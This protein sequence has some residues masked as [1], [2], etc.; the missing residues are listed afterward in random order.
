MYYSPDSSG[1]IV[2]PTDAVLKNQQYSSWTH[3]SDVRK[4][5]DYIKFSSPSG[6]INDIVPLE[7]LNN[8]WYISY[9]LPKHQPDSTPIICSMQRDLEFKLWH[10]RLVHP[11]NNTI[12][13]APKTCDGL[14][15]SLKAPDFHK[16]EACI[17]GK[18]HSHKKG[19][20]P[21]MSSDIRPGTFFEMDFGFIRGPSSDGK[22]GHLRSCRNGYN[23]Y[24]LI[25]DVATRYMWSFP[26]SSKDV[27]C[28]LIEKFLD[29]YGN[30]DPTADRIVRTDLGGELAKSLSFK[31]AISSKNFR[32]QTTA[33]ESSFQN[34]IVEQAHRT[35]ADMMRTMLVSAGLDANFWSDALLHAT[36][37]KNRL[38][39]ATLGI[40][41]F[42]AW[43]SSRP[44]LA[45]LRVFGSSIYVRTP[46]VDDGKLDTSRMH[47]G[48][49][50][51]FTPSKRN[52]KYFDL[53]T[54]QSKTSR[55]FVIDEA[56]F[57]TT[58]TIPPYAKDLLEYRKNER[59]KH[60][61]TGP[62]KELS[63]TPSNPSKN[64]TTPRAATLCKDLEII[65]SEL[66]LSSSPIGQ[67]A[68]YDVSTK[69]TDEYL[70]F[71]FKYD[72]KSNII[73]DTIEQRTPAN[74]IPRWRSDLRGATLLSISGELVTSIASAS[75]II[76]QQRILQNKKISFVFAP[77]EKEKSATEFQSTQLEF[78]QLSTIA[79]QH[80]AS[81]KDTKP[82]TDG[83]NPPIIDN[84]SLFAFVSQ[85]KGNNKAFKRSFLQ[86]QPDWPNWQQSEYK[87]LQAYEDQ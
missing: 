49:F 55:H 35:L 51:G 67:T 19:Y 84:D 32:L 70:G 34:G 66:V 78:D 25:V 43:T 53:E 4:G 18:M 30:K 86:K 72:D 11:G 56:H 52:V 37:V 9:N 41:P 76:Q 47:K 59:T 62:A 21:T 45:H 58:S 44:D 73:L 6:L 83:H 65:E 80:Q 63:Y 42:E 3:F 24:L 31:K 77:F 79:Y 36:Y 13:I 85:V 75:T 29:K 68:T 5:Q 64:I 82:W 14:P 17:K 12:T 46:G 71:R 60:F 2:S 33:P 23:S 40:T 16:C 50:L 26:T 57:G 74:R 87:Q 10:H 1:T 61:T 81:I 48:I 38:P 39:H 7:M 54:K 8:L 69:G 28:Q 27:P 15:S 22:R 20:K